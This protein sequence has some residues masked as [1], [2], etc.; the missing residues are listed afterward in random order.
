MTIL[1]NQLGYD[2]NGTKQAVYQGAPQDEAGEFVIKDGTD[3]EVFHGQ[4]KACGTVADWQTGYYWT[5]DFSDF[6]E[7]GEYRIHLTLKTQTVISDSFEIE[8]YLV[9]MRLLNA[10]NYYFK[11]QRSSGEWLEEDRHVKFRGAREGRMDVHGGWYDATGD[12]GVHLSHLSHG[13]VHNP[14]QASFSAYVFFKAA[15]WMEESGNIEYTMMKRRMLDE[16]CWGADF[17]MRLRAPSGSFIRSVNRGKALDHVR[18][19]RDISF[20]YHGSSTQFSKKA[21]TAEQEV[22]TDDNYEVSLRSGGG[23]AIAAL[24]IASRYY[25]PGTDYTRDEYLNAAKDAWHYLEVNNERYTNDGAWNLLDEYCALLALTELYRA[26]G[27]YEYLCEAGGMA[28]RIYERIREDAKGEVYLT[29]KEEQ[30]FFHAADEGLP[31]VC[32]LEYAKIE[33]NREK[34]AKARAVC[35][36]LMRSL[37][38]RT[39]AVV[40]PF[41]YPRMLIEAGETGRREQF[42][43]PHHTS[44]SPWWQG[45]N[46]RILSLSTAARNMAYV[47]KDAALAERLHRFADNQINWIMGLNPFDSCMMEGYGKNNV[48]YFFDG[49]YDFINCP[50]GICNGITSGLENEESIALIRKPCEAIQDNWRWAEQWIPH[51]SWFICAQAAKR[52]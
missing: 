23:S 9:S 45:D 25:Y 44:V 24:A 20:E 1:I 10:A 33:L 52:I 35:E 8:D 43:F 15:E 31:I 17:L 32:L 27:E 34:A 16:G 6:K 50:G 7:A 47:T 18:D 39:E 37:L 2:A 38:V 46:A 41:D 11:A 5:L 40:N 22:I 19:N 48:E 14:Q 26:C 13:S 4:A 3:R 36:K 12:Y 29:V 28:E 51:V 42:F 49:R 21:A 30:P